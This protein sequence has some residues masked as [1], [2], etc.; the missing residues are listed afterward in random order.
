MQRCIAVIN[1]SHGCT[2]VYYSLSNAKESNLDKE[3]EE[4]PYPQII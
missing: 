4:Q 3:K 2:N 1:S